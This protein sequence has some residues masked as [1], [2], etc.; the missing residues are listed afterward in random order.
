VIY[1]PTADNSLVSIFHAS[2]RDF[3]VTPSRSE[4]NS[5]DVSEGHRMLAAQCLWCLNQSL[6]YNI[7]NLD[8]NITYSSSDEPHTI[9]GNLQYSCVHEASHLVHALERAPAHNSLNGVQ[10]LLSVSVNEHL[11][12]WFGCLSAL[13]V[14]ESGIKSFNKAREAISVSIKLLV[15]MS[16]D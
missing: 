12:H 10:G 15:R 6:R 8:I 16:F 11:L 13:R 5:L 3:I 9:Q 1:V 7:C 4:K 14:L 2:F